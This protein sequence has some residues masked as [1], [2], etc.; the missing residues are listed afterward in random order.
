M[1]NNR[2]MSNSNLSFINGIECELSIGKGDKG[3]DGLTTSISVNGETYTHVDG[4]IK[5]PNYPSIEG[6]ASENYV[7]SEIAKAQLGGDTGV[8]L[9]GFA[10][11]DDLKSKVDKVQGYSLVSDSEISRLSKVDNYTHPNTHAADMILF[12]DGETFQS[13]LNNGSLKGDK[14]DKGEKGEPGLSYDD[15]ELRNLI[16]EL[17]RRIEELENGYV[18]PVEDENKPPVE[19]ENEPVGAKSYCGQMTFKSVD[20]I[21]VED[22]E[23]LTNIVDVTKPQTIYSHS[24]STVYNKTLICAI[25]KSEGSITSVVD[26]AGVDIT[27]SYPIIEKTLNGVVYSISCNKVAQ[28]YNKST[29]VKFNIK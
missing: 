15:A 18:P 2:F 16:S 26:G 7:K 10:T 3:E 21:T 23:G 8:D 6:L 5:L 29:V 14:G 19:D 25:P 20:T 12:A 13:K 17:T 4:N 24:G 28:A 22:L 1:I 27:A 11:K 9:S